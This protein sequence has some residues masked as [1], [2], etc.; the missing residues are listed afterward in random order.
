[1]E[2][3]DKQ[4]LAE[5]ESTTRRRVLQEIVVLRGEKPREIKR[6]KN[7]K[8]KPPACVH[9]DAGVYVC[10]LYVIFVVCAG[11]SSQR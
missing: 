3:A 10:M 6:R 8:V 9:R 2:K 7:P 11:S 5:H 4:T 1:M